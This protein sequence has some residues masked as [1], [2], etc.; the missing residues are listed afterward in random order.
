MTDTPTPQAPD[1]GVIPL[2]TP[3][4]YVRLE[5]IKATKLP[6]YGHLHYLEAVDRLT[7]FIVTGVDRR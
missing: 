4:Q 6:E 7:R 1:F 3:E 2:L 5:L